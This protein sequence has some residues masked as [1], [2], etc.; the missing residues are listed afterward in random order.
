MNTEG[1]RKT[2]LGFLESVEPPKAQDLYLGRFFRYSQLDRREIHGLTNTAIS[3]A[4]IINLAYANLVQTKEKDMPQEIPN[5][6]L[7]LGLAFD[8][9]FSYLS[10]FSG[11][12]LLY[13]MDRKNGQWLN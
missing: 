8:S 7:L 13:F 9:L 5:E 10:H 4:K 12:E 3:P 2:Q 6:K 11:K 1:P